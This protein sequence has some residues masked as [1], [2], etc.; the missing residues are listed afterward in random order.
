MQ[1]ADCLSRN[2]LHK[3]ISPEQVSGLY[4][5]SLYK[6]MCEYVCVIQQLESNR[7][8]GTLFEVAYTSSSGSIS[9]ATS[10][11]PALASAM[12]TE[13]LPTGSISLSEFK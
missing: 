2:P 5:N 3:E 8:G 10:M 7:D 13:M 6:E 4:V 9:S 1:I 11:L 12:M